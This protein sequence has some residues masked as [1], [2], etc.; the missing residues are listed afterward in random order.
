MIPGSFDSATA[1]EVLGDDA[2]RDIEAKARRD[3]AAGTFSPPPV[4]Q[5]GYWGS[6]V[7]AMQDVIYREQHAKRTARN[8]RKAAA[9]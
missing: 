1:R 2:A 5:G 8:A 9:A 4:A 6:V 7:A 3:A